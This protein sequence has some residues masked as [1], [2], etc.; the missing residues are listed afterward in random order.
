MVEF[1]EKIVASLVV[2][3]LFCLCTVKS[4][5]VMQQCGY[6]NGGFW[7]W[8]KRRDNLLFNRLS[9]LAL[10][11]ALGTAVTSLCFSFLGE[12]WAALASA[13]PF[14][15]LILVFWRV[16]NK[17]ALKVPA[18]HTGRWR[19]LFGAY[20]FFT[21]LFS[22]IFISLLSFLKALNGST[23]Y[24]LLAYVPFAAMP[25]LLPAILCVANGAASLFEN[26]RNRK[27]VKR[28][29]QA[30][31]EKNICRV[32]VVGSYGKTSVKNILTTLLSEKFA[33]VETPASYNTPMGIAK[34]VL[35]GEM[36]GKEIFIAEMG[37]R[38]EGD[39]A[40]LCGLVKP[41]YAIF[42][43]V[44]EQHIATF[45]SLDSVFAEKSEVLRY[46]AK[47]VVCGESLRERVLALDEKDKNKAIFAGMAQVKNLR[48]DCEKTSFTLCLGEEVE[49]ET[50]LLGR[51]AAENIALAATL[52]K[53]LGMTERE[54]AAGIEK[55]QPIE[56]RLQRLENGGVVILDDGY[57]CNAEGAKV[58]L[59]VLSLA[60]GRKCVVTPGIVEGGVLEEELNG[61]LG[62][63]L[64][65]Y[66][67][68]KVILVGDTLVGTVKEGYTSAG[69]DMKKLS[70]VKTL[71]GAQSL[72]RDFLSAGDTVLF[73]ND[74]PD[75]Y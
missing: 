17:Y 7:K 51:A 21:A 52:C 72:L 37:A 22:F 13:L 11:L 3:L 55:L 46:A 33:V 9:V 48:L 19:R 47:K 25:L 43:G 36:G 58:A 62:K 35:G 24:A 69:G 63:L 68:D 57:N 53:E 2:S 26:A 50:R 6:K 18:I 30:L 38:K 10:C 71:T 74:L 75:A 15:G 32:A 70:T 45:G 40:E 20:L 34:T 16:D 41:D 59:E 23:L 64:A 60:T 12:R 67:F 31:E 29:G 61:G 1:V 27:F 14:L 49:V 5:G 4:V 39:I 28:A 54:I 8:L 65:N 66:D 56:H 44:C 73:L 42:T